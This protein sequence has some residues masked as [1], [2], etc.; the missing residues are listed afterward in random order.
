VPG[1]GDEPPVKLLAAD[2][3]AIQ[4]VLVAPQD[5]QRRDKYLALS[6]ESGGNIGRAVGDDRDL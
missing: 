3:Q 2:V 5:M 6:S 1:I 4:Q